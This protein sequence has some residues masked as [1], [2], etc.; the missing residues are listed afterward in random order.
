MNILIS[1]ETGLVIYGS[2][3]PLRQF[4]DQWANDNG[5]LCI[6][7]ESALVVEDVTP[8]EFFM[9]N[10]YSYVD[11]VWTV[12]N[13]SL[14]DEQYQGITEGEAAI[15]RKGRDERLV[16]TDWTQT[17]DLP[18]SFRTPWA[19]YRQELRDMSKNPQWPWNPYP[20]VPNIPSP[21]A[22]ANSGIEAA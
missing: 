17:I 5:K 19:V 3:T 8:P 22:T 20:P 9:V 16:A 18:S 7:V 1:N 2:E 11:G 12:V 10:V 21:S 4:Q 15:K 14:Y 6:P 13:Q